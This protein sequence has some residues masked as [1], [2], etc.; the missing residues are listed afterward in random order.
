M[1]AS[2][3]V[4]ECDVAEKKPKRSE[5]ENEHHRVKHSETSHI[6]PI[7]AHRATAKTVLPPD[8]LS[9]SD[10]RPYY[11]GVISRSDVK[12]RAAA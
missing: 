9:F 6:R 2:Q 1:A 3:P 8:A 7:E 12:L 5:T 11:A 10:C 4:A